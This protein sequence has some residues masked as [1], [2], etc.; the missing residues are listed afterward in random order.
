VRIARH[1]EALERIDEADAE[2]VVAD[3]VTLG[4]VTRET[5]SESSLPAPWRHRERVGRR[6]LSENRDDLS[7]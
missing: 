2:D 7:W 6:D 1:H 4:L 3:L 5:P